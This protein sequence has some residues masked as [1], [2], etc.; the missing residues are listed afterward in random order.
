MPPLA[1]SKLECLSLAH[2]GALV[3]SAIGAEGLNELCY[4]MKAVLESRIACLDEQ[5]RQR[6]AL[7]AGFQTLIALE[8]RPQNKKLLCFQ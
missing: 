1:R 4:R 2:R 5:R 6:W 7:L 8:N 3:Q